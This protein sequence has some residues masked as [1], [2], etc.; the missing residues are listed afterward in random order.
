MDT[1]AQRQRAK[2]QRSHSFKRATTARRNNMPNTPNSEKSMV[3]R[4][5]FEAANKLHHQ[6]GCDINA[7]AFDEETGG[8]CDCG[9]ESFLRT[10][11]AQVCDEM[12]VGGEEQY[13][14]KRDRESREQYAQ[15][16]GESV[17]AHCAYLAQLEKRKGVMGV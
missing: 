6:F 16:T 8:R 12:I 14:T 10:A 15:R 7:H 2:V 11:I 13:P 17:G 9:L 1:L 5:L 3:E 4:I